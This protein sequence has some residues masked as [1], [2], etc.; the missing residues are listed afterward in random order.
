MS[1]ERLAI[2]GAL[3]EKKQKL[4]QAKLMAG[5]LFAAIRMELKPYV[6]I[7]QL[8]LPRIRELVNDLHI[9]WRVMRQLREEI[10][11]LE[12]ELDG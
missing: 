11:K 3:L 12:K 4:A 9:R 6:D 2:K 5:G 7:W 8:D 10:E 1:T